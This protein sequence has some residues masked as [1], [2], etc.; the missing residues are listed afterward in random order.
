MKLHQSSTLSWMAIPAIA[1]ATSF[2]SLSS[3]R[4]ND[5]T[6]KATK[7]R[8]RAS[9]KVE[10]VAAKPPVVAVTPEREAAAIVFAQQNHPELASLLEGLK[11]NAPKEYQAALVELDRAVDQL[12]KIKGKS[13][14]RYEIELAE[15]KMTSRIRLLAARLSMYS[16]PTVETELRNALRERLEFRI[17]AQRTERDRMQGRV[18]KLDSQIEEMT[19]KA[20]SIVEKQFADLRKT[21]PAAKPAAKA[22]PKKTTVN[23]VDAK[24]EKP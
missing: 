15:W 12:A 2:I 5:K 4:A 21:M 22:K 14:E 16:D 13:P 20:D 8:P 7:E 9:A 17:A 24:G 23:Q 18:N 11:R 3:S 1:I 19:S 10:K 6:D